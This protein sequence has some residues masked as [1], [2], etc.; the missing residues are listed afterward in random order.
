MV[1][2][3]PDKIDVEN[4]T[5]K[6]RAELLA[7]LKEQTPSILTSAETN[8][9]G[10]ENE[11]AQSEID[12]SAAE[13]LVLP[14]SNVILFKKP[15]QETGTSQA[16]SQDSKRKGLLNEFLQGKKSFDDVDVNAGNAY[17]ATQEVID[18]KKAA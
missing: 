5:P 4:L 13:P 17:E 14:G 1:E 16:S 11:S 9:T 3:K 7:D 8:K 18:Q 12:Q 10:A 15:F 6:Q 2:I